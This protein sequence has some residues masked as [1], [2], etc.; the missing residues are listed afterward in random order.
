MGDRLQT[1][2]TPD[3]A[4]AAGCIRFLKDSGAGRATILPLAGATPRRPARHCAS[5]RDA[6]RG[7]GS[8]QRPLP[9]HRALRGADPRLLARG[10]LVTESL[11]D[12]LDVQS[13]HP[14][15]PCVSLGGDTVRAG[16]VEG[17]RG[18]K[19]L[20]APRR[21]IREIGSTP[22]PDRLAPLQRTRARSRG[23]LAR[24]GHVRGG[25]YAGGEH[26]RRGEGSR[27]HSPRS[28]RRGG[29]NR[30]H[31]SQGDRAGDRAQPGGAG[32]ARRRR[33]ASPRS[34]RRWAWRRKG[35]HEGANAS[36][37]RSLRWARPVRPATRRRSAPPRPAAAWR[38]CAS[39]GSPRRPSAAA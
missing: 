21:E 34:M 7:R 20:L 29:G 9:G 17:G 19:G 24:R 11:E 37:P 39:A 38:P 26:P 16:L 30:P 28:R 12:A 14:G 6:S 31:P 15:V 36:R 13:C 23:G 22:G 3:G 35:A 18:V 1:L 33:Y 2:L 4:T 8:R 10:G 5:W 32:E 27:G 25:P